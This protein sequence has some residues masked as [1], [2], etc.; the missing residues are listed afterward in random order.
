PQMGP[1]AEIDGGARHKAQ[2]GVEPICTV[3]SEHGIKI[4]PST[5]YDNV[6]RRPSKRTL[7][8]AEILDL[9]D[10]ARANRFVAG[11]GARKMWLHL[12]GHGHDAARCTIERI[13]AANGLAG[14]LRGEN[15]RTTIADEKA[16]RPADL[17]DR[18]FF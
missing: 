17:V 1:S 16:D 14:A 15:V 11:F 7:R 9:I 5:Y 18:N 4:A 6:S 13:M 10:K 2:F 8:D 12:R 3:L